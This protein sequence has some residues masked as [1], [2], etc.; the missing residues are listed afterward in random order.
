MKRTYA[1]RDGRM[2]EITERPA[3]SAHH[4]MP[5]LPAFQSSDGAIIG[6]RR[7]WREHL[8]ATDAVEMGVSDMNSMRESWTKRKARFNER[9]AKAD[10]VVSE[11]H[12]DIPSVEQQRPVGPDRMRSELANRLHNRPEPDRKTLIRLV[13][14]EARRASTRR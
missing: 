10:K 3:S 1:W 11:Y 5:D 12:G 8:K 2:V 6:G 14:E 7:Q 13:L 4:V 9:L